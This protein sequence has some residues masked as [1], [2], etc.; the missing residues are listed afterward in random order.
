MHRS[1]LVLILVA[2]AGCG[3]VATHEPQTVKPTPACLEQPFRAEL[4]VDA[5]DPRI[6]WA[7]NYATGLDVAVRPRP[8]ARF[9]FDPARPTT[10]L[11]GSGTIVSFS[12][13]ISMTGCL[14]AGTGVVYFGPSDL[15]NPN[16]P[17]N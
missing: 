9:T 17:P 11:D 5:N 3:E 4:H 2:V 6:V 15:P 8:P 14:D 7:T 16:R 10:L 1:L 13:E 12:G